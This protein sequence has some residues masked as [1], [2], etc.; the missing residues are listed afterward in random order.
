MQKP[1]P[2]FNLFI[3]GAPLPCVLLPTAGVRYCT[4]TIHHAQ[5]LHSRI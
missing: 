5:A 4:G 2:V 1:A 3:V